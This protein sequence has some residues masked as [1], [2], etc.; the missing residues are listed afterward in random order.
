VRAIDDLVGHELAERLLTAAQA[1]QD[2]AA[3]GAATAA[4]LAVAL[5]DPV[6]EDSFDCLLQEN[7]SPGMQSAV[8]AIEDHLDELAWGLQTSVENGEETDESYQEAFRRARAAGAVK[9]CFLADSR[10]MVSE[11]VYEA[12]HAANRDERLGQLLSAIVE[13]VTPGNHWAARTLA[14]LFWPTFIEVDGYVLLASHYTA[15]NLA[16][17]R[18]R[19]PDNRRAIEDVI[20]HVHVED[21][22]VTTTRDGLASLGQHLATAWRQTLRGRFADRQVRVEFDGHILTAFSTV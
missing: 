12:A 19:H 3:I 22:S 4:T 9:S 6:L 10:M 20:N 14:N 15:E 17:W 21:L 16:D 5:V 1:S 11:T 8:S 18:D 13:H 7:K 2:D